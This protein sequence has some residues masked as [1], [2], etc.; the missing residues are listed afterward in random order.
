MRCLRSVDGPCRLPVLSCGL[1]E[2]GLGRGLVADGLVRAEARGGRGYGVPGG[3]GRR[4]V[5][6][7]RKGRVDGLRF[8]V[9]AGLRAR[10]GGQYLQ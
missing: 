7:G 6:T 2:R 9:V 3:L 1:V 10:E 5:A 4:L 8:E